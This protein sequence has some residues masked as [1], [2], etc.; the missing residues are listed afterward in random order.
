[1]YVSITLAHHLGR[2]NQDKP[3]LLQSNI[4]DLLI[5]QSPG[6]PERSMVNRRSFK[7]VRIDGFS[8]RHL[9]KG[10][11]CRTPQVDTTGRTVLEVP[12]VHNRSPYE[13][14][15]NQ[16]SWKSRSSS[17]DQNADVEQAHLTGCTA[18]LGRRSFDVSSV[19][20]TLKPIGYKYD[21]QTVRYDS[22]SSLQTF[23]FNF[24]LHAAVQSSRRRSFQQRSFRLLNVRT[25]HG[26][27][28]RSES[29]IW[30]NVLWNCSCLLVSD[31]FGL[32]KLQATEAK[33]TLFWKR[34]WSNKSSDLLILSLLS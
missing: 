18:N 21:Q 28:H 10:S 1:M 12:R 30:C 3:V 23:F 2:R 26:E 7:E 34:V 9:P 13:L 16:L 33:D 19:V 11:G 25:D 20:L 27:G 15:S 4:T 6:C 17:K 24:A 5:N 22:R 32:T 31:V 8:L 29:Y 14:Y